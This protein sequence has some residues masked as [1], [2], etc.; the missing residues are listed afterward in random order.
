MPLENSIYY[1]NVICKIQ[2]KL[3]L[4]IVT[5]CHINVLLVECNSDL[6]V[7]Q[8]NHDGSAQFETTSLRFSNL[9]D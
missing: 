6:Q 8:A 1:G 2:I 9:F 7:K 5:W 3:L 4:W